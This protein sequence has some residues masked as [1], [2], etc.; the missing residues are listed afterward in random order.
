[1][2]AS[3]VWSIQ[4]KVMTASAAPRMFA[5]L[6]TNAQGAAAAVNKA[7]TSVTAYGIACKD[8]APNVRTLSTA[9]RTLARSM[10]ILPDTLT[11]TEAG[12]TAVNR[13]FQGSGRA[14]GT[15]AR[16][17]RVVARASVGS[18]DSIKTGLQG[19]KQAANQAAGAVNVMGASVR[20]SSGGTL[21]LGALAA[22][23]A[24]STGGA[25]ATGATNAGDLQMAMANIGIA[26]GANPA[27]LDALRQKAFD[28]SAATAQSVVNSAQIMAVMAQS[29][30]N[31]PNALAAIA[32]P[33]AKFADVQFLG[34]HH[35]PF[36][37]GATQAIQLAHL[38][39]Q[40]GGKGLESMFDQATRVS[41]MMPDTLQRY[42]TQ[43]AYYMPTFR[44]LGVPDE[45]AFVAGAFMDR[46]GLGRGK[47]GTGLQNFILTQMKALAITG[48]VQSGQADALGRLGL[49]NADGSSR[50]YSVNR[51]KYGDDKPHFDVFGSLNAI[52][53]AILNRTAGLRGQALARAQGQAITDIQRALNIQGGRIGF[54]GT[55]EALE[56]LNLMLKQMAKLPGTAEAQ[57]KLMDTMPGQLQL[58]RTN[59][60][61]LLTDIMWPWLTDMKNT[62]SFLADK[63]HE[64]QAWLHKNPGVEKAVGAGLAVTS[65]GM[66][67]GAAMLG[68]SVLNGMIGMVSLPG[69]VRELVALGGGVT[70]LGT[71]AQI[72]NT[73]FL[74]FSGGVARFGAMLLTGGGMLLS[75]GTI[76][77]VVIG[78][79]YGLGKALDWL[80]PHIPQLGPKQTADQRLSNA[81]TLLNDAGGLAYWERQMKLYGDKAL[82]AQIRQELHVVHQ[83]E[84][85]R[86]KVSRAGGHGSAHHITAEVKLTGSSL[87]GMVHDDIEK[88]AR[89]V[90]QI[91]A[92]DLVHDQVH[93]QGSTQVSAVDGSGGSHYHVIA[94]VPIFQ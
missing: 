2:A 53:Q 73:P 52:N 25:L 58:F 87:A 67:I 3:T 60:Q 88:M 69:L 90:G 26:T 79:L 65:V 49:L 13:A 44:R 78:A 43:A 30:I 12:M 7:K 17:M 4:L 45:Q 68:M 34:S 42:V 83:A 20:R 51:A 91:L 31:D 35:V 37:Q 75:F 18:I 86:A 32:L 33:A 84:A 59:F 74:A 92:G 62:F 16:T 15:F 29:G 46:M 71:A 70:T 47:G 27:Q 23:I 50:F 82:P 81:T 28:V 93:P 94:G 5:T 55:P 40:Y 80:V 77:A 56:Q 48:H 19:V 76:A 8:A 38:F 9:T 10:G 22:S 1:M 24:L 14:A 85:Y 54:L 6:K 66:G 36:T 72:A 64:I 41:Q 21:M 63:T 57:A 61:S 11:K 89:I 39:Q